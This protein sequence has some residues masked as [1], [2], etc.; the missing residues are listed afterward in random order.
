[1]RGRLAV[2]GVILATAAILVAAGA[3]PLA[4]SEYRRLVRARQALVGHRPEILEVMEEGLALEVPAG[5]HAEA[6]PASSLEAQTLAQ[7]ARGRGARRRERAWVG[8]G[9]TVASAPGYKIGP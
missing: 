7:N 3:L 2:A 6:D 5:V 9:R 4:R 8:G 1:M